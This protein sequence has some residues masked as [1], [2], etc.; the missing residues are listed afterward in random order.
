ML[1]KSPIKKR[2]N[3][4]NFPPVDINIKPNAIAV[5]LKTPITVSAPPCDLF[6][7]YVISRAKIIE[8]AI[9]PKISSSTPIKAPIAIPV[10]APC[11]N[12]SEKNA[13]R[14]DT[15]IVES[16]PNSGVTSMTAHSAFRINSNSN[17]QS[18]K[19][20]FRY[21]F[22]EILTLIFYEGN[23]T[24]KCLILRIVI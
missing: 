8:N 4:L 20:S 22:R 24:V 7:M 3:L 10:N 9:K 5:E 21:V 17:I 19:F 18:K 2:E 14:L 13:I 11:P 23:F 12:E 6:F 1:S 16:I 15:T